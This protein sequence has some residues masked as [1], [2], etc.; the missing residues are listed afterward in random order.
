MEIKQ[1]ESTSKGAFFIGEKS[2][3]LAEMTYS[4][5]GDEIIIIDH[6]E[7]SESLKGRGA[8]KQLVSAAVAFARKNRLR[9][10]PLCTFAKSVFDKVEEFQDVLK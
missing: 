6:T 1:Y 2:N 4:K 3:P 10:I 8:G 5:A 7:V 9:V